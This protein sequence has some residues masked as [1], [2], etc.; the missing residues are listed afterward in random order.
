[1]KKACFVLAI[2]L[3]GGNLFAQN[4]ASINGN[5]ISSEEFLWVYQKNN[6]KNSAVNYNELANYLNLYINFKL[7]VAEAKS[8]GLDLDSLYKEEI[9]GYEQALKAQNKISEGSSEYR[10]VM[11]EYKE[12]VLMFNVS[13]QKVWNKMPNDDKDFAA[14]FDQP[15]YKGKDFEEVRGQLVAD[16]QQRIEAEWVKNLRAK[17]KVK[18]NQA[19]LKKLAK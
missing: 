11:N 12:G 5:P 14:L 7:K 4:I 8:L 2:A 17:Y 10:Y 3:S 9:S 16:Y 6:G 13:E 18:I 15:K 1:M 19:E